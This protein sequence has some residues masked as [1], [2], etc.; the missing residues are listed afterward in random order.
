MYHGE[1][2]E[3]KESESEEVDQEAQE[4]HRS[5]RKLLPGYEQ[6]Q[7]NSDWTRKRTRRQFEE[8]VGTSTVSFVGEKQPNRGEQPKKRG[9]ADV[10]G[11]GNEER[12][13]KR[14]FADWRDG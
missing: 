7:L 9:K 12:K 14:W 13:R 3:K 1:T 10:L 8:I 4:G 2:K 11:K 6:K 5:N